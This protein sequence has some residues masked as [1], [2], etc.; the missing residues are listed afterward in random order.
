V[1]RLVT[2]SIGVAALRVS[3]YGLQGLATNNPAFDVLFYVI[4]ALGTLIALAVLSD[5]DFSGVLGLFSQRRAEK[6]A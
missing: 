3:G 2:A 5:F 6:P 1:L 4:P